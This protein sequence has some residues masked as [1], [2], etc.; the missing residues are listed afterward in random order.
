M[1]EFKVGDLLVREAYCFDTLVDLIIKIDDAYI[2]RRTGSDKRP[3][4]DVRQPTYYIISL[5]DGVFWKHY[6]VRKL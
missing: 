4:E 5:I 1:S 3:S 2:T 6:P